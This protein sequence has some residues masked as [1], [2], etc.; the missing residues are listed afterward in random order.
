MRLYSNVMYLLVSKGARRKQNDITKQ[1]RKYDDFQYFIIPFQ[2]HGIF[3]VYH[4]VLKQRW[5]R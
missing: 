1:M 5:L 4:L 3:D 2:A